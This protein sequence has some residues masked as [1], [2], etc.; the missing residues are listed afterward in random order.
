MSRLDDEVHPDTHIFVED[1]EA[2]IWL[3][4]ILASSADTSELLRRVQINPVGPANVV[5]MLGALGASGKLPYPSLAIVDGDQEYDGCERLP[6]SLAPERTVLQELKSRMWAN[7]PDRFGIG[8][9]TLFTIL[10]DVLLEPDHHKWLPRIGDQVLKSSTSVWEILCT[11]WSKS[12]LAP[13]DLE[14]IAEAI[15]KTFPA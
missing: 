1:R 15:R 11:E 5:G 7:L 12:C 10:D 3:R 9:G 13:T 2:E 8:A 6:G 4:E 14:R